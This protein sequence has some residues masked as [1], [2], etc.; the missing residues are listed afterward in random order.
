M[1]SA[2]PPSSKGAAEQKF[3]A[4]VVEIIAAWSPKE[5]SKELTN[6]GG[7]WRNRYRE[8]PD[9]AHKILAEVRVLIREQRITGTP[10]AAAGDLWKRLP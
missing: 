8:N 9:K 7:W 10:G 3:L 6:W 5:A 1:R 4:Q 2:S